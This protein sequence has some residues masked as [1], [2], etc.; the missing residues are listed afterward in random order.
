MNPGLNIVETAVTPPLGSDRELMER[1]RQGDHE[2]F[3]A[4]YRAHSPAVFRFA[5]HM[6]GNHTKAAEITQEVFVWLIH[7]PSGFD[8]DRGGLAPFL[9]GVARQFVR[10][11]QRYER[12][13]LPFDNVLRRQPNET[14]DPG[15]AIDAETFR[16]AI[17]VLPLRYRE[18]L[19]LCY[20]EG[21]SYEE[22]ATLLKCAVG[23]IRSRLYRAHELLARKFQL[24]KD[25]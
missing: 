2:A 11:Q 24:R 20:L 18:P 6:T 17:A 1:F 13:W 21:Y 8:P 10:Q 4:L 16:K 19:V 23:T 5:L 9:A 3:T 25:S 14:F 7:H 22:A 15:R 12:R